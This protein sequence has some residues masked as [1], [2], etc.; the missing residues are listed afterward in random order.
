MTVTEALEMGLPV[1]AYGIP[2]MG[3]L[4]TDGVEGKIVPPFEREKLVAAMLEIAAD[5]PLREKMKENAL[6]K[7]E[8][9]EPERIAEVWF[10]LIEKV[11]EEP[12]K[13]PAQDR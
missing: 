2:A 10:H 9:L 1:V 6:K 11:M 4:V 12:V 5:E 13:K 7:A 3:P 8:T